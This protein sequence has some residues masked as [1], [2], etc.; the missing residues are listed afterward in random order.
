[1]SNIGTLVLKKAIG[2]GG[3]ADVFLSSNDDGELY[4]VK[5]ISDENQITAEMEIAVGQTIEHPNIVRYH[6]HLSHN[7]SQYL[8][9][10]YIRGIHIQL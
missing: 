8:I 4:A 6:G 9:Y 1:M 10:D 2:S 5:V 7:N 3:F